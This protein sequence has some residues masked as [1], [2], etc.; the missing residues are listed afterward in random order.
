MLLQKESVQSYFSFFNLNKEYKSEDLD[1]LKFLINTEK[2][3]NFF[4]N[5]NELEEFKK[6]LKDISK[7][8]DLVISNISMKLLIY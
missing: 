2:S 3:K 8:E 7:K 5:S 4:S 1:Y 6:L